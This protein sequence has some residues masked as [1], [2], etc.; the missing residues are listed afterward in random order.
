MKHVFFMGNKRSGTSILTRVINLHPSV[1]VFPEADAAWILYCLATGKE[2]APYPHDGFTGFRRTMASHE[3]LIRR[4]FI[5]I[6]EHGDALMLALA[7][8]RGRD[9]ATLEWLGDK[10]PV[11]QA[12]PAIFN[13]LC[14]LY[15]DAR[16]V[17]IVR[18]PGNFVRSLEKRYEIRKKGPPPGRDK[19]YDLWLKAE[20][21]VIADK[22]SNRAPIL[23]VTYPGLLSK[24]AETA[25][26]V[27][28]FLG[29]G[30]SEGLAARIKTAVDP[31]RD[32]SYEDSD[33]EVPAEVKD[34]AK[35]YGLM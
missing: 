28:E 1:F 2:L 4:P 16:F 18:H 7:A 33:A 35:L 27:L 34:M 11:Q 24:P 5:S 25:T 14:D 8:A 13:F 29:L 15:P 6:A 32:A 30:V 20:R 22:A 21:W 12:D 17:H 23:S 31:S 3:A 10:K 26:Q 19:L 9:T